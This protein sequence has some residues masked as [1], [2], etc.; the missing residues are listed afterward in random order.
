M[1]RWGLLSA[2]PL[3][4]AHT[5]GF[6]FGAVHTLL[7]WSSGSTCPNNGFVIGE[8]QSA[9]WPTKPNQRD[10]MNTKTPFLIE[11]GL[12]WFWRNSMRRNKLYST[13]IDKTD[14]DGAKKRNG[15]KPTHLTKLSWDEKL[16]RHVKLYLCHR[17]SGKKLREI[18]KRFGVSESGVTRAS[19]RIQLKQ[20]N[21]KKFGKLIAKTVKKLALSNV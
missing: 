10:A 19:R 7:P 2:E 14:P 12:L 16:A 3:V 9:V 18:G 13:V 4:T 8:S 15:V 20:K 5:G 17:Y 1:F 11:S 6:V 21:D